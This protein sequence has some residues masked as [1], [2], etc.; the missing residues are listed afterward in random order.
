MKNFIF[1]IFLAL[2]L[3]GCGNSEKEQKTRDTHIIIPY[4]FYKER[5]SSVKLQGIVSVELVENTLPTVEQMKG[6]AKELISKNPKFE[7][8]FFRF[9][10]PFT[11]KRPGKNEG[12]PGKERGDDQRS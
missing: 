11:Q 3:L 9:Q 4:N 12:S 5:A 1:F 10:F 2:S 8:Y 7:N 6:V